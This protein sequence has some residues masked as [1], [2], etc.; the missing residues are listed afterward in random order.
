MITFL[1]RDL[2]RFPMSTL[3]VPSSTSR[4]CAKWHLAF[5]R[6]YCT[7]AFLSQYKHSHSKLPLLKLK[8]VQ[9]KSRSFTT[10]SIDD[11]NLNCTFIIDPAELARLVKEKNLDR[12]HELGGA[13]GIASALETHIAFGIAGDPEDVSR[14]QRDF[15]SNTYKKPPTKGFF[16]FVVEAF[17]DLTILILLGCAT[18]S[19]GFG[20]KE[21]G[22]DNGYYE[23]HYSI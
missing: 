15:G 22:I 16:H 17:K 13:E 8:A 10:L 1:Q 6:I 2:D 12:V 21:N 11:D 20:I 3:I 9:G 4:Y 19:L 18:L 14:R 5:L 23:P 7:R